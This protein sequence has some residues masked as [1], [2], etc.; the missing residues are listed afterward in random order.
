MDEGDEDQLVSA[1]EDQ[2][3]EPKSVQPLQDATHYRLA[4][5]TRS[6]ANSD[7]RNQ[8]IPDEEKG[9][10]FTVGRPRTP[11]PRLSRLTSACRPSLSSPHSICLWANCQALEATCWYLTTGKIETNSEAEL[12]LEKAT[13]VVGEKQSA[14]LVE[15]VTEWKKG[16]NGQ[17]GSVQKEGTQE[18]DHLAKL[19]ENQLH[20]VDSGH[21]KVV[22]LQSTLVSQ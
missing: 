19:I 16:V 14:S 5:R 13:D 6:T 18:W 2:F 8:N 1:H 10:D 15:I 21:E 20:Q 7:P 11:E 17:W 12:P 9:G 3:H 22:L 4:K